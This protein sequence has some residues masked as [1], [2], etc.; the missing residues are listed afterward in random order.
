MSN[1]TPAS[2]AMATTSGSSWA[3]TPCPIRVAPRVIA[4]RTLSGPAASPPVRLATR[5][6]AAEDGRDDIGDG[7]SPRDVQPG[8][9]PDLR[10]TDAVLSQVVA[11]FAG[12]PFQRGRGLH[13][14]DRQ[15]EVAD[16][17][18]QRRAV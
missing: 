1:W 4:C 16:V 5:P 2:R 18:E 11:Q 14:R 9:E 15:L 7:Q 6:P 13:H 8:R 10:V 17:G 12:D 3:R